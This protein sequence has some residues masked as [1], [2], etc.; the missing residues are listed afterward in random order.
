MG[1]DSLAVIREEP[2]TSSGGA[3][4]LRRLPLFAR[5]AVLVGLFAAPVNV[6][7][8]VVWV[9]DQK[10]SLAWWQVNPHFNQLW[11]T[12][13]PNE[14][15]WRPGEGRS[16]GW[17]INPSLR[18]PKTGQANVPDTV[19]VPFYPRPLVRS[20]CRQAVAGRVVLPDT[21]TWRGA[22]GD[23]TVQADS[24]VT[25]EDMRDLYARKLLRTYTYPSLRFTIDS[26][27]GVTR[28]ADTLFATAMGMFEANGSHGAMSAVLRAWPEA[29]GTEYWPL[30]IPAPMLYDEFGI[31]KYALMGAGTGIWKDLFAGVDVLVRPEE[32]GAN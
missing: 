22:H 1:N 25:G 32:R 5:A 8:Q 20:V 2:S 16:S 7:A 14:S 26:L 30:R 9:V 12:T 19:H 27:V 17:V 13:C 4:W 24:L 23:V 31:S 3:S 10:A 15:S 6:Q 29:G 18:A 21:V 11:A 28:Q